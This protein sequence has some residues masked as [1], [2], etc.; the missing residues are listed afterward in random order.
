MAESVWSAGIVV[1]V[2]VLCI[3]AA[4]D[5][6]FSFSVDSYVRIEGAVSIT[7]GLLVLAWT[8]T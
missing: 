8:H 6:I 2:V 5:S 4:V 1:G 3:A 7:A